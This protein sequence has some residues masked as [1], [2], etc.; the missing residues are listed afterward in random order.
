M[1]TEDMTTYRLH[2]KAGREL[3]CNGQNNDIL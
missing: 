3:K 1:E 2:R